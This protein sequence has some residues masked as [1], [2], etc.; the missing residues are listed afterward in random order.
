MVVYYLGA[1]RDGLRPQTG[2]RLY[3]MLVRPILDYVAHILGFNKKQ[4][5]KLEQL[6]LRA[7]KRVLGLRI[8]TKNE[9]VRLVSGVEPLH[10][11]FAFLKLKHLYRIQQKP[12]DSLVR[13]VFNEILGAGKSI[14]GFVTE[15]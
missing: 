13:T 8:N 9:S 11:R 1:R 12:K 3:K 14:P 2:I 10:A 7:L 6:Q 15:C 5:K 4:I